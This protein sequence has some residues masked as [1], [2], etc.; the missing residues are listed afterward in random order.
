MKKSL[1]VLPIVMCMLLGGG[2]ALYAA[3]NCCVKT[4]CTC[5]KGGCCVNGKCAC[6]G[7]CCM[8]GDCRCAEGTCN[9]QC[10]CQK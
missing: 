2:Y 3:G 10:A 8:K 1:F 9:A 5:V 7:N 6:K 4:S